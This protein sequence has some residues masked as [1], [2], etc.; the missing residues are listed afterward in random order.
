[1][2]EWSALLMGVALGVAGTWYYLNNEGQVNQRTRQIKARS[3]RA[4]DMVNNI[5]S[6]AEE[7]LKR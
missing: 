7:M 1:M 3:R 2:R 5:G 6:S 4:M